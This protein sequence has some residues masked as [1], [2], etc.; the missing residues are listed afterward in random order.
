M[1]LAKRVRPAW[2]DKIPAIVHV[3][4]TARVQTV[5]ERQNPRLYR[6]L[7][8][9]EAL[10]GVPVLVN[11]SFNVKGEPI[12]ETPRDALDCFLTTGIDYLA[13]HDT[14]ISKTVRTS[15][16][17]AVHARVYS[18]VSSMVRTG[19]N[20]GLTVGVRRAHLNSVSRLAQ[21][22]RFCS[23]RLAW[24]PLCVHAKHG[25]AMTG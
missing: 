18:E 11:T 8:E 10:T 13:L 20:A 7:K 15:H 24:I 17:C 21:Q 4:G 25:S 22:Q 9:F 3:D 5:R 1:L 6:L 2:R 12:V 14:L 16:R 19:M 23:R